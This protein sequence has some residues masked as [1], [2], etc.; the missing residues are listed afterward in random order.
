M[1]YDVSVTIHVYLGL[2]QL[3][4]DHPTFLVEANILSTGP[5]WRPNRLLTIITLNST[6]YNF[7]FDIKWMRRYETGLY[8]GEESVLKSDMKFF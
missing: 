4:F 1:I 5:P 6:I 2:L 8:K 3:G 7:V